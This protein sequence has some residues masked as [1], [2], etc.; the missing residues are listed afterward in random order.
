MS[1]NRIKRISAIC[2]VLTLSTILSLFLIELAIRAFYQF[3]FSPRGE[4]NLPASKTYRLSQNEHLL[5]ELLPG[6]EVKIQGKEFVTNAFGFRDKKYRIRK[7]NKT[8]IIFVGDSITYG[9]GVALEETYHKQ[10]ERLL[11]DKGHDVDVMG[12]GIPGYNT[13][14]EYYLIK[15]TVL[16][17]K[18]DI[19][20]LQIA[21]N[22][23]ERTVSIKAYHE[24][25]KLTLI[26]Y[27]DYSIPFVVK[28]TKF[29]YFLM[30]N[31]HLFK[32]TNL[33]LSWLINKRDSDYIPRDVFLLGEEDS[34]RHIE[35]IKK[36]LDREDIRFA[37]VIFPFQLRGDVDSFAS[38]HERIHQ[39]LE[40]MQVPYIDLFDELN[41]KHIGNIWIERLHPNEHGHRI[42]SLALLK[43]LE[44]MLEED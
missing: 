22:D 12:M 20:I 21:P 41:N 35:E 1:L 9:W 11:Y 42:A 10:I 5:Y 17:F 36:L 39:E 24:G 13:I 2:I 43:F 26:P 19:L 38:L 16:D 18:P 34:F 3:K 25:E 33:R 4:A 27:H 31:S 7:A 37:A 40:K 29:T 30:R 6:S 14:Q 23:F 28:K 32:L 44:P 15:E 8:R